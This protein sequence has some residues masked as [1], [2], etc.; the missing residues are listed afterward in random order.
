MEGAGQDIDVPSEIFDEVC[1]DEV[2]LGELAVR[3]KH[4]IVERLWATAVYVLKL[5]RTY[6]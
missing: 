2:F 1:R 5:T 3:I 4:E 6:R